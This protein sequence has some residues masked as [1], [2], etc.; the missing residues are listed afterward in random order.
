MDN[1]NQPPPNRFEFPETK[2]LKLHMKRTNKKSQAFSY[3][4]S[5]EQQRKFLPPRRI[6]HL[7]LKGAHP[8]VQFLQAFF[9]FIAKLGATGRCLKILYICR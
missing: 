3:S 6:V 1:N 7:D 5:N 4:S 9:P 2:A 8:K